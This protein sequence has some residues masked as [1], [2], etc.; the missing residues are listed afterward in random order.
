MSVI[1]TMDQLTINQSIESDLPIHL[2]QSNIV[3]QTATKMASMRV[4]VK[5]GELILVCRESSFSIV[6]VGRF[7][8]TT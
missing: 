2:I 4:G 3:H 5:G 8:Y 1:H 7:K 6:C